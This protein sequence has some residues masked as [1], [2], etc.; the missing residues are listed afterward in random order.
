MQAI[1]MNWHFREEVG[2]LWITVGISLQYNYVQK[3]VQISVSEQVLKTSI[4]L[5]LHQLHMSYSLDIIIIFV[6]LTQ[7]YL[8]HYFIFHNLHTKYFLL[9]VLFH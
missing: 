3:P 5:W 6:I 1:A 8:N 9:I 4:L 7:I 2:S